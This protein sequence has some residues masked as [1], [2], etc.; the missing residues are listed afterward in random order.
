[1]TTGMLNTSDAIPE[2]ISRRQA[3]RMTGGR[4]AVP[5]VTSSVIG[6]RRYFATSGGTGH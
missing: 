3:A 4:V 2:S 6:C 1:V 5:G